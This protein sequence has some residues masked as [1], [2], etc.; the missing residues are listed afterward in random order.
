MMAAPFQPESGR[1]AA[2]FGELGHVTAVSSYSTHADETFGLCVPRSRQAVVS[3][4]SS[5]V[6]G[7]MAALCPL[8]AHWSVGLSA[9][10]KALCLHHVHF[11]GCVRAEDD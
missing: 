10:L 3:N 11:P 5:S 7:K 4:V 2:A 8:G 1:P 9:P 6:W